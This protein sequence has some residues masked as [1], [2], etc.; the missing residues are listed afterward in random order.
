MLARIIRIV[1][2]ACIHVMCDAMQAIYYYT[3]MHHK[4][5]WQMQARQ[6][7]ACR[8]SMLTHLATAALAALHVGSRLAFASRPGTSHTQQGSV[9][10]RLLDQGSGIRDQGRGHVCGMCVACVACVEMT[11]K[12]WSKMHHSR[13]STSWSVKHHSCL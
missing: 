11:R 9:S 7:W 8:A 3:A 6:A 1:H 4:A 5:L 12:G 10:L 2:H 13:C